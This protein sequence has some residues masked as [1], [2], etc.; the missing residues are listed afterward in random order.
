MNRKEISDHQKLLEGVDDVLDTAYSLYAEFNEAFNGLEP[1]KFKSYQTKS[2]FSFEPSEILFKL[3]REAYF[4]ELIQWYGNNVKSK[5]K[6]LIKY[7]KEE[8]KLNTFSELVLSIKRKKIAPFIGAGFS[9]VK[10]LEYP[11]WG[12]ALKEIVNRLED[13]ELKDVE[14]LLKDYK[15]LEAAEMLLEKDSTQFINYIND[16]FSLR[17]DFTKDDIFISPLKLIPQITSGCVITTNYDRVLE[18]VFK[19]SSKPFEGFMHG[20]Q[21]NSRFVTDLIRGD[22]C[23]LKLHGNVGEPETYIF[24]LSQYNDA[25]GELIDWTRPLPKTLRQIYISHSL[26]FLGCSMEQDKTLELF[27][28]IKDQNEFDVPDHFAILPKPGS[29]TKKREKENRLLEINIKTIWYPEEKHEFVEKL[30]ELAND[31]ANNQLKI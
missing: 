1:V 7:L 8:G 3:D 22:R 19:Y 20:K 9:T 5:H 2:D 16:R 4:A 29:G 21:P 12:K 10:P 23:L 17:R 31:V 6:D 30:L 28:V 27:K 11:L 15:Y 24:S 26:L 25:Y 14:E 13:L 18:E